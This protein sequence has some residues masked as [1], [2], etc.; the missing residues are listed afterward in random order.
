LMT[1]WGLA[2][3]LFVL[4]RFFPGGP[5]DEDVAIRPEIRAVLEQKYQLGDGTFAAY[6]KYLGQ[7]LRGDLGT[8]LYF[9]DQNVSSLIVKGFSSTLLLTSLGLLLAL[10]FGLVWGVLPHLWNKGA[11]GLRGFYKT[12]LSLPTLFLGPVL[13]WLFCFQWD[14]FPMRVDGTALSYLLPVFLLALRPSLVMGQ[15]LDVRL[16]QIARED[17]TRTIQ[18]LG[19]A[20]A[21]VILRWSLRPALPVT[22]AQI[23]GL[24]AGLLSGSLLVETLFSIQGL[25]FQFTQVLLNRDWTMALGLTLFFGLIL[26][27]FQ[28]LADLLLMLIDPR[29]VVK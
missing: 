13:L 9:T 8:S 14:L 28:I 12:G 19:A 11:A 22:L 7:A 6:L 20:P 26:I 3:V 1:L 18:S 29:V 17:H 15:L 10:I 23:P 27:V 5:F 16:A 21:R 4:L 24:A 25:G 2:T